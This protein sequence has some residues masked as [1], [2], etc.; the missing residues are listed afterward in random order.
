MHRETRVSNYLLAALS[1][2]ALVLLSLP[3]SAPVRT[4]KAGVVYLLNP[5][6]YYGARGAQRLAEAPP[7][8]ARLLRADLENVQL[9]AQLRETL[10]QKSELEA[11]RTE[12]RRLAQALGLQPPRGYVPLWADVMERDPLHWYNSI[13]IGAGSRQGVTLNAPVFGEQDGALVAVGRVIEARHDSALVLLATDEASSVAA[14]LST[15]AV[16]GLVQGQGGPRMR[17]NYLPAEVALSTGDLV[18]TSPTSATFPGEILLGRVVAINPRDPF[19][20]FQSVEVRPAADAAALS[21]VMVLR[22]A[23]AA[24]PAAAPAEAVKPPQV[25]QIPPAARAA[26]TVKKSTGTAAAAAEGL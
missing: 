17:M 8:L 3:L 24:G 26:P 25:K 23:G 13:M 1:A 21:Q 4:F 16:E 2:L 6:A 12:N 10:W 5:L 15:S 14:Y 22:A 19:L 20:T 9:Q 11:L 18:Y 7:G